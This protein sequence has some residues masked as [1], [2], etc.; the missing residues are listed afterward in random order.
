[1]PELDILPTPEDAVQAMAE[2]VATLAKERIEAENRFTIALSGGSSPCRLYEL[3][4]SPLFIGRIDWNRWHVFWGDE[5]CVPP[6]H[7]D[8]NYRMARES[9]L[10]HVPIPES[11]IHRMRGEANPQ[12]AAEEY[13]GLLRQTLQGS[14]P[15][16]DLT[17]LGMGD[18]GHTASL[19]PNTDAVSEKERLVVANW[20]PHLQAHRITFT[21]PLINSARAIALLVTEESK[22][23]VLR[24]VLK[25]R[26]D[27][28]PLPASL[29]HP[30]SGTVHWFLTTAAAS[31]L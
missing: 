19:F 5:R 31:Q 14:T 20:A 25:P 29:V 3:L 2:F 15:S 6:D 22:A 16:F 9:L 18:D 27:E 24:Q 21:L 26:S 11:Q 30:T 4:A 1:M 23:Q 28:Q 10:D 7:Q 12:T 13:E 17:L 8:S